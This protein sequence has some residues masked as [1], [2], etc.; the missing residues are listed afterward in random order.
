[1]QENKF[2]KRL[3]QEMGEF[4]LRPSDAVWEKVEEQLKKKK[5]RRVVF[6]IFML[7]GLSLLGYSGYFFTTSNS[8]QNLVQ[9]DSDFLPDNKKSEP[10]NKQQVLPTTKNETA[11]DKPAI[12]DYQLPQTK[13]NDQKERGN[14]LS[15]E[16]SIIVGNDSAGK[17]NERIKKIG[18]DNHAITKITRKN[19]FDI[20]KDNRQ[21]EKTEKLQNN[22][23]SDHP[24]DK[25]EISQPDIAKNNLQDDSKITDQKGS[26]A[27]KADSVIT[28]NSKADEAIAATK[29]KQPGSKIKWGIDLSVGRSSSRNNAFSIFDMNKSLAMDYN[30]PGNATG[31]GGLNN[32]RISPSYV[33]AGPAFRA[34]LIGEM[35]VS[36]RSSISSGLQYG[37]YSNKIQVGAYTDTT[38]VV[39][40]SY[41]Q[42][43]RFD[44]IYRG[45]SQK[46]YTNRFHFIQLPV[47]YQLQINKGDKTPILWS[48]GAAA[49]YL[50][51]TNGLVY[52]TA[53][54]GIYY[55][56]N[57]AFNKFQFNLN[58]GLSFRF[59]NKNKIQWSLGPELSLGMNKL[60]KDDYTKKQYLLYSGIT[61][62]II[63]A[64][65]N[66]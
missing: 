7:A 3:Q 40:N 42:S 27:T 43:A 12:K 41:S 28:A 23:P 15:N 18:L 57:A 4:R 2:E 47:Q 51:A 32:A 34:G 29:K 61:G 39:N 55:R 36:K 22:N 62:R 20:T 37:Y 46:N 31:G 66:K 54:G 24:A 44:A 6:F 26:E 11:N 33:K 10:G 65:K 35:K 45:T 60:M 5:R 58:T 1:M 50:F 56:D 64:K 14:V 19:S 48:I 25:A 52:D 21:P 30:S 16:K 8:K 17:H 13:E 53:A 63:F 59:G 38:V 9:Q 49:G